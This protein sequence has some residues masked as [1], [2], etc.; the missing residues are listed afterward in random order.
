VKQKCAAGQAQHLAYDFETN[1]KEERIIMTDTD[2]GLDAVFKSLRTAWASLLILTFGGM[3]V[4]LAA[5]FLIPPQWE[6]TTLIENA[7][8]ISPAPPGVAVL[9]KRLRSTGTVEAV[10][11]KV[12]YPV[13]KQHFKRL[14]ADT[15]LATVGNSVEL[16]TR[17]NSYDKA[18][19]VANAF[20]TEIQEQESQIVEPELKTMQ[21]DLVVA[22][23]QKDEMLK[24]LRRDSSAANGAG[25]AADLLTVNATIQKET[26]IQELRENLQPPRT[27]AA[28]FLISPYGPAW[29]VFPD[30]VLFAVLGALA[31]LGA[32][33]VRAFS[34]LAADRPTARWNK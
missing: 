27:E 17:A 11:K 25:L 21:A 29:P 14:L 9:A 3:A 5:A 4:G 26:A 28:R 20:L 23:Q 8:T 16:R 10:L 2:A 24:A 1:P 6:V 12:G 15:S 32:G 31:G 7:H 30:K 18:R 33:F 34:R 13:D 22:E 19:E